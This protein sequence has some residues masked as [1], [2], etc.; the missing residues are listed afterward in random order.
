MYCSNCGSKIDEDSKFCAN[1][2]QT[3]NGGSA[4][5]NKGEVIDNKRQPQKKKM[6]GIIVGVAIVALIGIVIATTNKKENNNTIVNSEE[7]EKVED[8]KGDKEDKE[9]TETKSEVSE[10]VALTKNNIKEMNTNEF[11]ELYNESLIDT[12]SDG[13]EIYFGTDEEYINAAVTLLNE[14]LNNPATAQMHEKKIYEKDEYGRAIV[15]IDVSAQNGFGGW[16]RYKLYYCINKVTPD[17]QFGYSTIKYY[18]E[19]NSELKLLK[20]MNGFGKNPNKS[21]VENCYIDEEK[22][23]VRTLLQVPGYNVEVRTCQLENFVIRVYENR[24]NK[25]VCALELFTKGTEYSSDDFNKIYSCMG[26]VLTMKDRDEIDKIVGNIFDISSMTSK[27]EGNITEDNVYF[28]SYN[29]ESNKAIAM[30]VVGSDFSEKTWTPSRTDDMKVVEES[31]ISEQNDSE[32]TEATLPSDFIAQICGEYLS[33]EE[34]RLQVRP[35]G[36]TIEFLIDD[37]P[38]GK[39]DSQTDE[40]TFKGKKVDG[41]AFEMIYM[42][43]MVNINTVDREYVFVPLNSLIENDSDYIIPNSDSEYL[44]QI[45]LYDL[46]AEERRIARNEIYARHGRIFNDEKLK[47]YF[48]SRTWYTPTIQAEDFTDDLLNDYELSNLQMMEE[49]EKSIQ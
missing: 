32:Q 28:E 12:V 16:S 17:G 9:E 38:F 13:E 15:Y 45:V 49:Y 24:D 14:Q 7:A 29:V 20:G 23:P 25:S 5:V 36:S 8:A 30:T 27:G 34:E 33:I 39:I 1:C 10:K 40:I 48:E 4:N 37:S 26:S 43:G 35:S 31:S 19:D 18:C 47:K 2:G 21:K 22:T 3:I 6:A 11:I 46:S 44:S 41:T 42:E